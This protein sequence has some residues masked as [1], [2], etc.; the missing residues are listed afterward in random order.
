MF[1]VSL[2]VYIFYDLTTA[3]NIDV[4]VMKE[5]D[6]NSPWAGKKTY[7]SQQW[8]EKNYRSPIWVLLVSHAAL[9]TVLSVSANLHK[10]QS[11]KNEEGADKQHY[12]SL[13]WPLV[14][15]YNKIRTNDL[16]D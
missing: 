15:D 6:K 14:W 8:D 1:F 9:F 2:I 13:F 7:C 12:E 3:E 16:E 11:K 4:L 5:V 10:D